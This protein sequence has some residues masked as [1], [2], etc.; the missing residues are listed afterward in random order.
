[1]RWGADIF[2][3]VWRLDPL[4]GPWSG[5]L[6]ETLCY[7][8]LTELCAQSQHRAWL[9]EQGSNLLLIRTVT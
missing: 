5:A 2:F 7:L 3:R 6:V 4:C 9:V 1:M 8:L